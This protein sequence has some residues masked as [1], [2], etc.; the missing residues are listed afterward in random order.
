MVCTKPGMLLNAVRNKGEFKLVLSR[1]LQA[2]LTPFP[3]YLFFVMISK[4]GE[5]PAMHVTHD[6]DIEIAGPRIVRPYLLAS[7]AGQSSYLLA[8]HPTQSPVLET[9]SLTFVQCCDLSKILTVR[10]YME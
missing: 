3:I 4:L 8:S 2:V 1:A 6:H 10:I 9:Q 5:S 7:I